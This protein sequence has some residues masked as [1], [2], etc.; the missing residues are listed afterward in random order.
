MS[1][2]GGALVA[3]FHRKRQNQQNKTKSFLV[4]AL[5][6]KTPCTLDKTFR[7]SNPGI[8]FRPVALPF[9]SQL[10]S[11]SGAVTGGTGRIPGHKNDP[12]PF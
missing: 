5:T 6:Q 10:L 2:G 3:S 8:S 11:S 9:F 1:G 12:L 4:A 7:Y